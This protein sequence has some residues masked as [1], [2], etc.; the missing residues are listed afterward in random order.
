LHRADEIIVTTNSGT[1]IKLDELVSKGFFRPIVVERMDGLGL[2]VPPT[3]FTVRDV[4]KYVDSDRL[5][6]VID[7]EQQTELQM[8]FGEF[9]NYFTDPDRKGLLNLIS[10]EVS[11]TK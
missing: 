2:R 1:D 10:L 11:N 4:E 8:N 5:V 9:A 7:V 6:D 3:N